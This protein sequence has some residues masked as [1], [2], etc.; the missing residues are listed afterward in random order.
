MGQLLFVLVPLLGIL[1]P[2]LKLAPGLYGWAIRLRI[3]H[4]YGELKILER[5]L[6]SDPSSER[7]LAVRDQVE[8]LDRRVARMRF[9]NAYADLVYELR[10]H[11]NLVRSRL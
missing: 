4:L 8:Q 3:Y 5:E 6:N 9:P 10:L 11:I 2:A 1:Y 7:K